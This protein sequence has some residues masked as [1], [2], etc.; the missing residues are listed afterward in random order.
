[1]LTVRTRKMSAVSL[2]VL[3]CTTTWLPATALQAGAGMSKAAQGSKTALVE[4]GEGS[5]RVAQGCYEAV[6][7]DPAAA[8]QVSG[9]VSYA[10]VGSLMMAHGDLF[11]GGVCF[12]TAR[13]LIESVAYSEVSYQMVEQDDPTEPLKGL[14][15]MLL[16]SEQADLLE[17]A[18]YLPRYVRVTR[19]QLRDLLHS[20]RYAVLTQRCPSLEHVLCTRWGL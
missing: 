2:F 13:A 6:V 19:I 18:K 1:M 17:V 3:S 7:N 11:A 10:A 4:A 9:A 5:K 8:S 16:Q 20:D 12:L 15:E 14:L